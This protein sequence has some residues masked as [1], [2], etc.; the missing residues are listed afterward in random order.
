MKKTSWLLPLALLA[1]ACENEPVESSFQEET[2]TETIIINRK[3]TNSAARLYTDT[4]INCEESQTFSMSN[5]DK[6]FGMVTVDVNSTSIDASLDI[7]SGEWFFVDIAMYAGN[8]G[9][10]PDDHTLYTYFQEFSSDN[11]ER[12]GNASVDMSNLPACG[13]LRVVATVARYN[14]WTSQIESYKAEVDTDYCNCDEPNEPDDKNLRTQ[15]PGGWG[16]PPRGNNPGMYLHSN[17]DAAF[18]SG[19][20]VGCDYSMSFTSAQAITDYLPSGGTPTSL[21]YSYVNPVKKPKNTLASH[22]IALTLSTTFDQWDADF[23]ESNTKLVNATITSGNFAGW[24]VGNV[25]TEA[26]YVLG[27]CTSTYSASQIQDVIS[28][29]NESFV[30]GDKKT[31]FLKNGN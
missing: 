7:S 29:I 10:I 13:C 25:L 22:V 28:K 23:G 21:T 26:N 31:D 17:F 15:T 20:R 9:T 4:G 8:C 3:S 11:E 19:L 27:G 30:D 12:Y 5:G 6:W 18:P 16:A 24:T 2:T 1:F 14:P